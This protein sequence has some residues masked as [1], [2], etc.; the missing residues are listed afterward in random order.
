MPGLSTCRTQKP[1]SSSPEFSSVTGGG[2][3]ITL[4]TY[5]SSHH[6]PFQTMKVTFLAHSC[7]CP[8]MFASFL[9]LDGWTQLPN[10]QALSS[11]RARQSMYMGCHSGIQWDMPQ[12]LCC[13]AFDCFLLDGQQFMPRRTTYH[14]GC[15]QVGAPFQSHLGPGQGLLYPS[16]HIA[17]PFICEACMV[18]AQLGSKLAKSGANFSL[19]MLEQMRL[20]VDQANAWAHSTHQNYQTGLHCLQ[21]FEW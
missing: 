13:H 12:H 20:L 21:C 10:P 6:S 15:I 17:P 18:C 2:S 14:L 3:A 1:F 5:T 8:V 16:T 4:L 11:I 7:T 9:L 19:L